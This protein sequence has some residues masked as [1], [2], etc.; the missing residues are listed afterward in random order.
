MNHTKALVIGAGQAGINCALRLA[1]AGIDYRI[2]SDSLGGR[3]A[4]SA[5]ER[6]NFGACFEWSNYH[7]A[8]K[9]LKRET[10]INPLACV[11]HQSDGS[12]YPT[13][14]LHTLRRGAGFVRFAALMAQFLRHYE[15]FKRNCETMS[16]REAMRRDPYILRLFSLPAGDWA[17]EHHIDALA[18][19]YAGLFSY[20]CSGIPM[21]QLTALDFLNICQGLV[22]P[23]HR[24]SFD[25][26]AMEK[27]LG[28]RFV[29]DR[30]TSLQTVDGRHVA[31][32]ASGE[33]YEADL[34][35]LATHAL[36]TQRL[37]GLPAIRDTC[38]LYVYHVSAVM[39]PQY[40]KADMNLFPYE[41][42]VIFTAIQ[43]DG[44]FLI[45]TRVE[46]ADLGRVC[47]SW[48]L[49]GSR[50][51]HKAMY[52][53]G[54]AYI[55]QQYGPTLFTAGDHNGLGMEPAA[56]SGIYAANQVIRAA[57]ELPDALAAKAQPERELVHA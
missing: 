23:I 27:R 47:A 35:V 14:S 30:V 29:R 55:E 37:L 15:A 43:D 50:L 31:S 56:I 24:F 46:G 12:A 45:Y 33:T 39:L 38:E 52:V 54:P 51:W 44:T 53:N 6:V 9:I 19:E 7:H 1:E 21:Q 49:I 20:A 48:E 25:E 32:G 3:V 10:W 36:E 17:H 57:G 26:A 13:T 5:E 22:L 40:A 42:P 41:S 11:F 8:K 2:V 18:A 16:Q 4:Y 34:V 28:A